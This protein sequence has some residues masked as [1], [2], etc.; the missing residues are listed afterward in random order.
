MRQ[1]G[2]PVSLPLV[3]I[4][5]GGDRELRRRLVEVVVEDEAVALHPSRHELEAQVVGDLSLGWKKRKEGK[6][7]PNGRFQTCL[8]C[9]EGSTESVTDDMCLTTLQ[10]ILKNTF[11]NANL[12]SLLRRPSEHKLTGVD[13]DGRVVRVAGEHL[14]VVSARAT[15]TRR[16]N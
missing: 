5:T 11:I 4:I 12:A 9:E 10:N 14:L 7:W 3:V 2:S 6:E 15:G 8:H 16:H 13:P 1:S